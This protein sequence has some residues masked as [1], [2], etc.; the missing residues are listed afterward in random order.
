MSSCWSI[1]L[2]LLAKGCLYRGKGVEKCMS[3]CWSMCLALEDKGCLFR[4]KGVERNT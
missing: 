1:C 3:S 2:A 4:G